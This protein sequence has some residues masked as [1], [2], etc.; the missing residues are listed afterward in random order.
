MLSGKIITWI[1][2]GKYGF[3]ST[4]NGERLFFHASEFVHPITDDLILG[5][6]VRFNTT[7]GPRGIRAI[8]I[9]I[10]DLSE[11]THNGQDLQDSEVLVDPH[12]ESEDIEELD[13]Q[14]VEKQLIDEISRWKRDAKSEDNDR[15]FW[16]VREVDQIAQGDKY[17]VIGRKGS[18]KTAICEYFNRITQP[19]VFAETLSFKNFPF[20]ELY[21]QK[22]TKYTAP[23]QFITL[24]K[25]LI[26]STVC[27]MMLK[28][29]SVDSNIRSLLESLYKDNSPLSRRVGQWVGK[30]F[31]MSL[32]GMSIKVSRKDITAEPNSWIDQVDFLE[33]LII[34][35]AGT[36]T[37]YVLFDALDEDYRDIINASQYEQYTSLITSLFKAVQD[38]RANLPGFGST[39][40]FPIIFLR[41]D[42]Y[43]LV[44]DSDKNKWGDFKVDLNWD[45][46]KIQKVMAFRISR[47]LDPDCDQVMSFDAAWGKL[48]GSKHIRVGGRRNRIPTFDF[49]ARSTLLRP[50]DFVAY[51]QNC[52]QYAVEEGKVISPSVIKKVD[53]GFS[54]YLRDELTDELF[55]ILPDISHI[56]D[57]ISQLRKWNFSIKEFEEA[58]NE[59]LRKGLVNQTSFDF[60]VQSLYLF[61][62]IGNTP[63]VGRYIFRYQNREARLN[64]NERIVVHR[65][66]FKALQII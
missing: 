12:M 49:I 55:A 40:V 52:A 60:V 62:V 45:Y 28:N 4:N 50:R 1:K 42:I 43:E 6:T 22:N 8:N 16:H 9:E 18:G 13:T 15:Y 7:T 37:Y 41:D 23:N 29:E 14:L 53:K 31:G 24:W 30:E 38:V 39:G 57:A 10:D 46:N 54:N 17:F 48:F 3:I 32:F 25:Y 26:Y 36:A 64:Y 27:R 65:G 59:K 56:F 2:N 21:G 61:S 44:Q 19:D 66:L 63:Y 51:L 47:A 5:S 34:H 35:Y 33:D 20:N 11:S 58:Y